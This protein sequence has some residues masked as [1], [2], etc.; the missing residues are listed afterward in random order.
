MATRWISSTRAA[1][2]LAEYRDAYARALAGGG[3]RGV[4]GRLRR[5]RPPL[6]QPRT[7]ARLSPG[8]ELEAGV[9]EI[10][11]THDSAH[12]FVVDAPAA[13]ELQDGPAL[14]IQELV[15][16]TLEVG[17]ALVDRTVALGVEPRPEAV[18]P[19]AVETA[20]TLG[21]V[22]THPLLVEQLLEP[23]ERGLRCVD[24]R[25]GIFLLGQPVVFQVE[26][27]DHPGKCEALE[28]EC[29][30]D[31]SEGEKDDQVAVRKRRAA[32]GRER[33]GATLRRACPTRREPSTTARTARNPVRDATRGGEGRWSGRPR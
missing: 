11:V 15:A 21:R 28:D 3:R 16:E 14:R 12:D 19:E 6:P 27:A 10:E 18:A 24:S 2:V 31:D 9:F 1:K 17:R 33:E 7:Q 20:Q 25:L 26:R 13:P 5:A 29:P 4:R 8:S 23:G 32:V 22:F 30:E